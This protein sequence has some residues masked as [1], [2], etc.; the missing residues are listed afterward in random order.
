MASRFVAP[1][2]LTSLDDAQKALQKIQE[3]LDALTPARRTSIQIRSFTLIAGEFVRASPRQGDTIIAKL[4]KASAEN[5]GQTVS[6]SLESPNGTL[7]VSAQAPDTINGVRATNY[8]S[9]TLITLQSNGVDQWVSVAALPSTSPG[10][11][12]LDAEYLLGS[13]DANLPNAAVAT[14]TAEVD[15][16]YTAGGTATWTLI[17]GSIVPTR[18]QPDDAREVL[19]TNA[20]E[21]A[22]EWGYPIATRVNTGTATDA[23][24]LDFINGTHTTA[25]ATPSA[26]GNAF[27]S[28]SVNTTTL[29]SAFAGAGMTATSGVMNVI[30][31]Q[32]ITVAA[33]SVSWAG[34]DVDFNTSGGPSQSSG[35]KGF[36]F[37]DGNA[38]QWSASASP[39]LLSIQPDF[40][41]S[42]SVITLTGISGNQGTI[43]ISSLK[44]GGTV[45]TSAPA[46]D[47]QVEGFTGNNT[48][49]FFFFWVSSNVNV[50]TTFFN[51]DGT[52]TSTNRIRNTNESDVYV[53]QPNGVFVYMQDRWRYIGLDNSDSV[54]SFTTSGLTSDL[55]LN[56]K[57][58]V[59]RVDTGNN[60]WSID[61]IAGGY[62]GRRLLLMN[63]SNTSS[64]GTL[65]TGG[66]SVSSAGNTLITPGNVNRGGE[67]RYSALL[68]YDSTDSVWRIIA[69][70]GFSV[71]GNNEVLLNNAGTGKPPAGVAVSSDQVLGHFSEGPTA[72]GLVALTRAEFIR[73][74]ACEPLVSVFEEEFQGNL[75]ACTGRFTG[76]S[77]IAGTSV[78]TVTLDA[79]STSQEYLGAINLSGAFSTVSSSCGYLLGASET[80]RN[81]NWGSFR[82]LGV[83]VRLNSNA[84]RTRTAVGIG[85]LSDFAGYAAAGTAGLLGST[86]EGIFWAYDTGASSGAWVAGLRSSSATNSTSSGV[87]ATVNNRYLLEIF[88]TSAG[89]LYYYLNG[90]LVRTDATN[91]IT[92]DNCTFYINMRGETNTGN[93]DIGLD[94]VRVVSV[95]PTNRWT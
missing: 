44:C 16:A 52:A 11:A 79:G 67:N 28:F 22:V 42:S 23:W 89:T 63:A 46:G 8:S 71:L 13:A 83:S 57:T 64:T 43:D 19:R 5:F 14:D 21:T 87:T 49:G 65:V 10:G 31:S 59:L 2:R 4:P 45:R 3:Q 29:A 93:R 68:E 32:Y 85:L 39:P 55:A 60:A 37:V 77:S 20:A 90:T 15:F 24:Q 91:S 36:D 17:D 26:G 33:D 95:I 7:R 27:V 81:F 88:K 80:A 18:L 25:A 66:S 75:A 82:Y 92:A 72:T 12:A 40:V 51:E 74:L 41:G 9:A 1:K 62:P 61:G 56:P 86:T 78:L 70:T 47:F 94:W 53:G 84:T 34:L 76:L 58:M 38:I 69:D 6:I 73:G 50:M 48:E 35:W 54:Q 30:G